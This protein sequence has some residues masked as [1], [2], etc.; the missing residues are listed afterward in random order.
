MARSEELPVWIEVHVDDVALDAAPFWRAGNR[1]A[2]TAAALDGLARRAEAAGGRLSFRVRE[3]FAGRDRSGFLRELAARGHEVGWHA[4]G[5]RLRAARDAVVRA[6][7]TATVAAPGLVQVGA[8][9][10]R[11]LLDEA[12]ALGAG[13]VTDRVEDIVF[14]YQGWLAWEPIAGLVGLDVSV[15]P[16]H[17]GVLERRGRKVGPGRLDGEALWSRIA[18][19]SARTAPPGARAF[20]GATF[21]EHDVMGAAGPRALE[22]LS[23]LFERLGARLQPSGAIA[24]GFRAEGPESARLGRLD[25]LLGA[26]HRLGLRYE[27]RLGP[28]P[29]T[30]SVTVGGGSVVARRVGPSDPSA[31]LVLVHGGGSGIGQ[32]LAPFG[33]AEAALAE[34]GLAAWSFARSEG[35]RPPGSAGTVAETRAVLAAALAEGRPVG[36]LTWSAGVVPALRAALDLGDPRIVLLADAEGP[37]DRFSLVPPGRPDGELAKLDPWDDRVWEGREAVELVGGFSGRYLRLQAENDHVHGRM[38]WHARRMVAAARDGRMNGD[39]TLLPG[40]L[41][42]HGAAI[43][44]WISEGILEGARPP[45]PQVTRVDAPRR[46]PGGRSS[47]P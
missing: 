18:A 19:A 6:G 45:P 27:Q 28:A 30:R 29:E 43:L 16:F 42:T 33:F 35:K 11:A 32:G 13:V 37:A 23:R 46:S 14:A 41:D 7:G 5:K 44:G 24:T 38:A 39:G 26:A 17:W 25:R 21:H 10:R 36:L 40:R 34:A 12:R 2:D 20:F 22:E 31:V 15:S 4:H 9:G 1:W 8:A 47:A 3:G